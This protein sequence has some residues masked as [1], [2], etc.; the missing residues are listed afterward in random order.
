[1]DLRNLKLFAMTHKRMSWLTKRQEVL[2]HNIAN[3]DTPQYRPKDLK[4]LKFRELLQHD[5]PRAALEKTSSQHISAL[6]QPERFRNDPRR[7]Q[8]ETAPAGNAVVIEEQLTKVSETQAN[9][10][11][12]TNLYSKHLEMIRTA[13]GK[14]VR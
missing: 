6:R 7:D 1:M 2:S 9:Y 12:A 3:A 11:L 8:Y 4:S 5:R 14:P 10:R 13:L